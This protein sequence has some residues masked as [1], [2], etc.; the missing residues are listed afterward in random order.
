MDVC[1]HTIAQR[2]LPLCKMELPLSVTRRKGDS[3]LSV[4]S[5]I[6][7]PADPAH[8]P[9]LL[10]TQHRC[11]P[12]L[13]P[14]LPPS[15][16]AAVPEE[17]WRPSTTLGVHVNGDHVYGTLYPPVGLTGQGCWVTITYSPYLP[18]VEPWVSYLISICPSMN[19]KPAGCFQKEHPEVEP[20]SYIVEGK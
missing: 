2:L 11:S 1:S 18:A 15:G 14:L 17:T 6:P 3:L 8:S 19:N 10:P 5:H 9:P 12:R 16:C 13:Q 7:S 20:G 4:P